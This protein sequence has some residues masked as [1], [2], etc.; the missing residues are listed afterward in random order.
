[1]DYSVDINWVIEYI[2][3]ENKSELRDKRRYVFKNEMAFYYLA[4]IKENK[5]AAFEG[6]FIWSW[7]RRQ[8]QK[9]FWKCIFSGKY[10][11]QWLAVKTVG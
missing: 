5:H 6:L 1:M 7:K 9:I 11:G 4:I 10:T 3:Y 8:S 2:L